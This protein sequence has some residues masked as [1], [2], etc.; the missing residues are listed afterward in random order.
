[1]LFCIII[2]LFELDNV[3][4]SIDDVLDTCSDDESVVGDVLDTCAGDEPVVDDALDTCAGDESVVDE[5]FLI[6]LSAFIARLSKGKIPALAN[7]VEQ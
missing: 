4:N 3:S 6:I 5:L 7:A 1:M 2:G